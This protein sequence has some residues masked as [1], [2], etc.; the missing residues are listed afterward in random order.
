MVWEVSDTLDWRVGDYTGWVD[1]RNYTQIENRSGVFILVD[2][3]LQVKYIGIADRGEMKGEIERILVRMKGWTFSRIK[4]LFTNSSA[5]AKLLM[6]VLIKKYNPPLN[7]SKTRK[8][9]IYGE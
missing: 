2:C 6:P 5:Y 9:L 1:V 4:V 8:S 3:D 7:L